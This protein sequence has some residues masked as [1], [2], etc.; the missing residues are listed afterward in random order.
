MNSGQWFPKADALGI[1]L[2]RDV[3]LAKASP[4]KH[5]ERTGRLPEHVAVI[6]DGNGRWAKKRHLPR[7]AGHKAGM[8][9]VK[10]IM[11]RSSQLGIRYL[12]LYA[13]STEN[14]NRPQNEVSFLMNLVIEYMKK[15]LRAM[16]ELNIR[17]STLGDIS[18]LPK[19]VTEVLEDAKEY[20][21]KN[22]GLTVNLA[23]NYGSRA[24]IVS[25]AAKVARACV[26]GG[27]DPEALTEEAFSGFL[28]T[29]GIPDPD[30]VIR[31]SGEER[32]SNFMLYQIAYAELYFTPVLWPD[33]TEE[34]YDAALAEYMKRSRRYGAL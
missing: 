19:P 22:S 28:E 1:C 8:R 27:L 26:S 31:T 6:M 11:T 12:T 5:E 10:M 3:Q 30:F 20:T 16:H 14:W 29:A 21:S 33:F 34:E 17:I 15:E 25:A 9:R 4:E 18:K 13:F 24:E 32:L 2:K 23:L 7:V